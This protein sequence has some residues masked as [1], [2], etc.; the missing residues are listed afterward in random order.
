MPTHRNV[1]I[2]ARYPHEGAATSLWKGFRASGHDAHWL[3]PVGGHQLQPA[4][5][6]LPRFL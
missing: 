1:S 6:P 3:H 4:R 5:P 2:E